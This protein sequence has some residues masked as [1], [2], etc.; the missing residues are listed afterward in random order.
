MAKPSVTTRTTKGAALTYAELDANFTNLQDATLT[1]TAGTGGTAVTADLNGTITLVAGTNITL[2]G[3]NSAKT[4]TI[5][6]S[7]GSSLASDDILVGANSSAVMANI[8]SQPNNIGLALNSNGGSYINLYD[9]GNLLIGGVT[10]TTG[11]TISSTNGLVFNGSHTL[12]ST[13]S[14]SDFTNGFSFQSLFVK[15][16]TRTTTQRNALSATNGMMIYNTTTNTFQGY[17][18]GTWVDFH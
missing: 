1:L 13:V 3:D 4:I 2:T 17:A 15:L 18:N 10:G 5:T 7:S 11:L 9:N 14:G 6:A 8:T 12:S 16:P